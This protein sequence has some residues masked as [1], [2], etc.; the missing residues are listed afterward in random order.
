MVEWGY[1]KWLIENSRKTP[2]HNCEERHPK[3]HGDCER[4]L[5]YRKMRDDEA[6]ALRHT[7]KWVRSQKFEKNIKR[8]F[9]NH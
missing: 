8:R 1:E 4:Y 6:E 5:E 9:Y 2:C 7:Y 3:C